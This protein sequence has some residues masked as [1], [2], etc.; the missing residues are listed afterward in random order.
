MNKDYEVAKREW[1]QEKGN[2][3]GFTMAYQSIYGKPTKQ[4]VQEEEQTFYAI[5]FI[6]G[7]E[8]QARKLCVGDGKTRIEEEADPEPKSYALNRILTMIIKDMAK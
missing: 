6:G 5:K 7:G 1:K 8:W 3:R 4:T 2:L